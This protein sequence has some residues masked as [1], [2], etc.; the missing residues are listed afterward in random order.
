M[1]TDADDVES[2]MK[3]LGY[4]FISQFKSKKAR[5]LRAKHVLWLI[6]NSPGASICLTPY[7]RLETDLEAYREAKELWLRKT[8]APNVSPEVLENAAW[9]FTKLD[10]S[11][12]T[13]LLARVKD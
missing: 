10:R 8:S 9:F 13:A 4:Y 11:L 5:A 12:A 1:T 2:R 7:V 6:D 3:L